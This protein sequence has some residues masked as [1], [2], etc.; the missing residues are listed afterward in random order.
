[1]LF[2]GHSSVLDNYMGSEW[3]GKPWLVAFANVCGVTIT[4][5][6]KFKLKRLHHP[7][8]RNSGVSYTIVFWVYTNLPYLSLEV[9]EGVDIFRTK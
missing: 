5:S 9:E 6:T 8:T 4:L 3:K 7:R 2:V 1:M